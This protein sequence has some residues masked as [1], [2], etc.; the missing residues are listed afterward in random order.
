MAEID[1]LTKELGKKTE[2]NRNEEHKLTVQFE[3]AD[4]MYSDA[5]L[6]YDEEVRAHHNELKEHTKEYDEQAH[7]L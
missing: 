1:K 5:L 3:S 2:Q 6:S 7:E 4:K